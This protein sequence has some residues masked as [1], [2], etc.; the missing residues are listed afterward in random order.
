MEWKMNKK[1][2]QYDFNNSSDLSCGRIFREMP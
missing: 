2:D 1:G